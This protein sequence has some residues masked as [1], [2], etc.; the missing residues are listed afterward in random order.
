ME[1]RVAV[2]MDEMADSVGIRQPPWYR[3]FSLLTYL[4]MFVT[5]CTCFSIPNFIDLT[6]SSLTVFMIDPFALTKHRF[7][8]LLAGVVLSFFFDIVFLS[9]TSSYWWDFE[10]FFHDTERGIRRFSLV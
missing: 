6:F 1:K 4:Y 8:I 2:G 9:I 3:W 7:R 10:L 5:L